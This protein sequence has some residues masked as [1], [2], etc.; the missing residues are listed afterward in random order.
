[1]ASLATEGGAE[2]GIMFISL[3]CLDGLSAGPRSYRHSATPGRDQLHGASHRLEGQ[4]SEKDLK[5]GASD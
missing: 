2:V 5:I 1:M 3:G 4:K